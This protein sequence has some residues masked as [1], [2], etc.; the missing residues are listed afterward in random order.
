MNY[1]LQVAA[2]ALFAS[3]H[4]MDVAANNLANMSTPGFKP[5]VAATRERSPASVEDG[6]WHLPSD[7]LLERLS[8]GVMHAPSRVRA[9]QG[10][11]ELTGR[12]LDLGVQ[13]EGFLVVRDRADA[14]GQGDRLTRNGRLSLDAG[15][16][17]VQAS[18]GLP[19]LDTNGQPIALDP[20]RST[21]ID[22]D[23][24]IRQD[25]EP[26]ARLQF[27]TVATL[28]GLRPEGNGVFAGSP[29]LMRSRTP[30]SGRLVQGS[31][32]GSAVDPVRAMVDISGAERAAGS[33]SRMIQLHDDILAR[34]VGTFGRV[35]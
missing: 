18:T 21:V 6:L 26:V 25:G 30:A 1:G 7:R 22:A 17:L 28:S 5:S 13:G 33:A 14:S 3:L 20:L 23:G 2:S 19:V 35:A 34:A 32:E 10:P 24:T 16:R 31:I 4:R 9:G 27:V 11:L 8:A 29:A 12:P 15:S